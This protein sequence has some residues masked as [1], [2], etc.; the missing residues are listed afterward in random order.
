LKLRGNDVAGRERA[1]EIT[2]GTIDAM[3]FRVHYLRAG[4]GAPLVLLHGLVGSVATWRKNIA[5]LA[6][7]ATVYALDMVNMGK[8]QCVPGL[9]ASLAATAD[10]VAACMDALGLAQADVAAHSHGGAV[11]LSLAARHPER[12]SRLVLFAPANPFCNAGRNLI[13]F[14]SSSLGR[15]VAKCIPYLPR[16]VYWVAVGRMYGKFGRAK[17]EAISAYMEEMRPPGVVAHILEIVRRW[18]ADMAGLRT[19]LEGIATIPTLLLWGD[20]D[21]AVAVSSGRKLKR[22]LPQAELV[23]L[24]GG[25]HLLFEEMPEECNQI[26]GNWLRTGQVPV[27]SQRILRVETTHGMLRESQGT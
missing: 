4:S 26:V 5:A 25:G 9:D 19:E 8:S 21:R 7:D 22:V 14:Y 17:R 3:G 16:P 2:E 6:E 1:G 24:P 23:V 27:E 13:R 15:F 20:C 11:A 18:Y 10:R 12:V